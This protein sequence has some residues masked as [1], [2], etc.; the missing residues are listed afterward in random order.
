MFKRGEAAKQGEITT[1]AK[2][3]PIKRMGVAKKDNRRSRI[4]GAAA[5]KSR[6]L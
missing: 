3:E 5:R 1:V 4:K 6:S 2:R